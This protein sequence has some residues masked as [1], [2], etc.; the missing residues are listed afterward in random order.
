MERIKDTMTVLEVVRA[1]NTELNKLFG[2]NVTKRFHKD[3]KET[4]GMTIADSVYAYRRPNSEHGPHGYFTSDMRA[5]NADLIRGHTTDAILL[6]NWG[7]TNVEYRIAHHIYKRAISVG[8]G[9]IKTERKGLLCVHFFWLS[10]YYILT[11]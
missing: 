4:T 10:I 9:A 2:A 7:L 11:H 3:F 1:I 8:F 5:T 6:I